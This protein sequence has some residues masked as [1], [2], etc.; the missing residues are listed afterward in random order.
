ML[1]PTLFTAVCGVVM[2]GVGDDVMLQSATL[3]VHTA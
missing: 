2:C 3:V 1:V